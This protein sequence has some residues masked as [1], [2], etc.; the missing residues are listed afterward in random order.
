LK[1]STGRW[2]RKNPS[3][4]GCLLPTRGKRPGRC[5]LKRFFETKRGGNVKRQREEASNKCGR[6]TGVQK[7]GEKKNQS[8]ARQP[9]R[10][11]LS[12]EKRSPGEGKETITVQRKNRE[13]TGRLRSRRGKGRVH[14]RG[15]VAEVGREKAKLFQ[16]WEL[17]TCRGR[18]HR[19]TGI[20][21]RR[22]ANRVHAP[23]LKEIATGEGGIAI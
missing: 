14:R 18:G 16:H 20:R 6:K 9:A 15:K 7:K 8:Q 4:S 12:R 21:K 11:T 5:Y 10:E 2:K 3:S 23:C 17:T 1:A 22:K 13:T 19:S